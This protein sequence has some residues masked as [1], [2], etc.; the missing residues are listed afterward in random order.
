[1]NW[2]QYYCNE[3]PDFHRHTMQ[4]PVLLELHEGLVESQI[5]MLLVA[6]FILDPSMALC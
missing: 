4:A 1:M 2:S 5:T 6:M 3:V